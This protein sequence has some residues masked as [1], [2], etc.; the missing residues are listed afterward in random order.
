MPPTRPLSPPCKKQCG[1]AAPYVYMT[2]SAP[3]S[4]SS[5][6]VQALIKMPATRFPARLVGPF[7]SGC[8]YCLDLEIIPPA[9]NTARVAR[10]M[11]TAGP[12]CRVGTEHVDEVNIHSTLC[13]AFLY[14]LP[15]TAVPQSDHKI[16]LCR[17]EAYPLC[18]RVLAAA[19]HHKVGFWQA[20]PPAE[21]SGSTLTPELPSKQ[22]LPGSIARCAS[23][24]IFLANSRA[25]A[26]NSRYA[27]PRPNAV[28]RRRPKK[29]LS[30]TTHHTPTSHSS[31]STESRANFLLRRRTPY[32]HE[33]QGKLVGRRPW[34]FDLR[35]GVVAGSG[36]PSPS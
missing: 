33:L 31:R 22:I 25:R 28:T 2:S 7:F 4:S 30:T 21:Q 36:P 9:S 1:N 16:G 5:P 34:A 12:C 35:D 10:H 23:F 3:A 29:V 18:C 14:L 8:T 19:I 20:K 32:S 15:P 6:G 13:F 27:I 11:S 26:G 17:T 24:T